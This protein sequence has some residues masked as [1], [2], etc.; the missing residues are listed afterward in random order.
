MAGNGDTIVIDITTEYK[1][2]TDSGLEKAS[3]RADKFTE[4][5]VKAKKQV[6]ALKKTDATID[7]KANDQATATIEKTKRALKTLTGANG[8][9][10]LRAND[11]ATAEILKAQAAIKK[12]HGTTAS[13]KISLIDKATA[14]L[15]KVTGKINTIAGKT[16]SFTA[17]VVDKVTAP[18]RGM[19]NYA[20][21]LKGIMTGVFT[22][23]AANAAILNPVEFADK[24]T[25]ANIGF[26]TK[27]GSTDAANSFMGDIEKF[28]IKTPFETSDL[29]DT[30][31]RML[32]M[33]WDPAKILADLEKIGNASAATGKGAEG[34][35]RISTALSQMRMKGKVSA[36]E[37]LQLTEVGVN[38]WKYL[39]DSVGVTIP[40]VQ[41]MT[42]D[43]LIPVE[44]AINGIIGG[45]GEF[46]G[47][48]EKTANK[49]VAGLKSQIKDTF[50][51]KLVLNWGKGLQTGGIAAL[52]SI[53]EW[54]GKNAD[55]IQVWGEK[56]K[57]IGTDLSTAA[58]NIAKG[59]LDGLDTALNRTDFDSADLL[60]KTQIVWEEVIAKPLEQ[61]W[62]SGGEARVQK[63]FS[64]V[65]KTIG[66][67]I[68]EGIP[69]A[70]NAVFSNGVTGTL[71]TVYGLK[72]GSD[73]VSGFT[74]STG[75]MK[76]V[77]LTVTHLGEAMVLSKAGFSALAGEASLL[78]KTF[79]VLTGPVGLAIGAI[80]LLTIGIAD[81]IKKQKEQK[82]GLLKLGDA[83]TTSVKNME[84]ATKSYD[85]NA[86]KLKDNTDL[87]K[88]YRDITNGINSG[89]FE[90]DDLNGKLEE[91]AST[92]QKL[93]DLYPEAFGANIS[94]E[95]SLGKIDQM[96]IKE[97]EYQTLL[98]ERAQI[99]ME[100]AKYELI[101]KLPDLEKQKID[102]Q[103]QVADQEIEVAAKLKFKEDASTA[104]GKLGQYNTL[105]VNARANF[106]TADIQNTLTEVTKGIIPNLKPEMQAE[107]A[108]L[109]GSINSDLDKGVTISPK[110]M[111]E[112]GELAGHAFDGL[113][114]ETTK[115]DGL[116][117]QLETTT[118]NINIAKGATGDLA[119][120]TD[121]L[122][123]SA[124][125]VGSQ[126]ETNKT[127][128][129]TT[130]AAVTDTLKS[131]QDTET[132]AQN[133]QAAA[134]QAVTDTQTAQT[135]ADGLQGKIDTA[136]ASL[137]ELSGAMGE[138]DTGGF[139]EKLTGL[140][141]ITDTTL[142]TI[143][144]TI[145]TKSGE[146]STQAQAKFTE[147]GTFVDN[148][149]P[150]FYKYGQAMM[151]ELV[152]GIDSMKS[153]AGGEIDEVVGIMLEKF[154]T[155]LG[156]HSPSTIL[157][158]IGRFAMK[159]L[160]LGLGGEDLAA[161][162]NRIVEDIKSAFDQGGFNLKVGTEFIG[163]GA[164]EFFKSIGVGGATVEGLVKPVDGMVTDG[165]GWR[166][167][168]I[169]GQQQFHSGIDIGASEGTPVLAAGAGEVVQAGWNGGYGNSVTLDHGNGLETLYGHL[170]QVL[171][172][173]G[174]MVSQLEKIGLVGST[175]NSTGPHLHFEI[176]QGG[177][178]I[179]PGAIWG[180]ARGTRNAT[181]GVH[182]VG[183]NGPELIGFEGGEA[184]LNAYQSKEFTR[185]GPNITHETKV[186]S[187][188]NTGLAEII[189]LSTWKAENL[190]DTGSD[191]VNEFK[192][193]I[194]SMKDPVI[195]VVNDFT[196]AV[197]KEIQEALDASK[198][199]TGTGTGGT[200]GDWQNMD[201][202]GW[203]KEAMAIT[204]VTGDDNF[205]H[206]ME[207]AQN[208][209]SFD[210]NAI[211]D[212][213]SNAMAG[214]PSMGLMQTIQSTFDAYAGAGKDI[215]NPIDNAVAAIN[216]MIDTYGSVL[217]TGT[218]GYATG[219]HSAPS[220]PAWVGENG[221]ELM[222]FRGGESV[223]NS[224]ES[225]KIVDIQKSRMM[226][227]YSFKG[228]NKP[229]PVV[230]D[231]E[232]ITNTRSGNGTPIV[233]NIGGM[234]G[235]HVNVDGEGSSDPEKITAAVQ[236]QMP[237]MANEVARNISK[238]LN[239][240]NSGA[241]KKIAN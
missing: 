180:Y 78:F 187:G 92:L 55:K 100:T 5:M 131:A 193:G 59:A 173:V 102:L 67:V 16:F 185:S 7:L 125:G 126:L 174:Q 41:K 222:N 157:R 97:Q 179:D 124:E 190:R 229:A 9:V 213:D 135:N 45:M 207:I 184:V 24:M 140:I 108:S 233:V 110:K 122:K 25:T 181:A 33:N 203:I 98:K 76:I 30:S 208:E 197:M 146:A 13:P 196:D 39:A 66:D 23:I 237:A 144:S 161:F 202:A 114:E 154:R 21:S 91:Q 26:E 118:S 232:T 80:A 36:E 47:M 186:A 156:I 134:A 31:Q 6:E 176:S 136:K 4:S 19:V 71:A 137:G 65:V 99:E 143:R 212:W 106:D 192:E 53:N 240:F 230:Y 96:I 199:T 44:D 178:V 112:L 62:N 101:A 109:V 3:K 225:T 189:D 228:S 227:D 15:T 215:W 226:R 155:G 107:A 201:A 149:A 69:M 81:S 86:Q 172:Q 128:A 150:E 77:E 113:S 18:L 89:A 84:D 12:L 8:S 217:N 34:V 93:K 61:W 64:G 145:E 43:G 17:A 182:W 188:E 206:L 117:S 68:T 37:M 220:G 56:L 210:P 72:M 167:H 148:M 138:L 165:F 169:T 191:M 35:D 129:D 63:I 177:S 132:S 141:G 10:T 239:E 85:E 194:I 200:G 139:S 209:S 120:T 49:T 22:A 198:L 73:F 214:T 57:T 115:L 152:S 82:E 160:M 51:T 75:A 46:D 205:N 60:G 48:M 223:I 231:Q 40:E 1:D 116:K 170:S 105:D 164:A 88:N 221:P 74:K 171:V 224:D 123:S 175:G 142:E 236:A 58:G 42:E 83:Y 235:V 70:L 183:E 27:L 28:A 163:S 32:A 79:T 103:A 153:N 151:Q 234:G 158:E 111:A 133:A 130:S 52:S 211:N 219:I 2:N 238:Y 159:G 162:C 29:I 20:T 54:I 95:E 14:G 147:L 50:D 90:G 195:Q 241:P 94:V 168:P 204:G 11:K 121:T 218:H 166:T 38:G 119:K 216:Y 87:V 104:F 127:T